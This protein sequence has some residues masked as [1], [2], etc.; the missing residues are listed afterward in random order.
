MAWEKKLEEMRR[1]GKEEKRLGKEGKR[2]GKKEKQL[3]KEGKRLGKGGSGWGRGL[4][5]KGNTLDSTTLRAEES[6]CPLRVHA[7]GGKNILQIVFPPD[8]LF[9]KLLVFFSFFVFCFRL[10]QPQICGSLN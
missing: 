10:F 2:L 3:G 8:P 5:L 6:G 4:R 7:R 1:L 9:K